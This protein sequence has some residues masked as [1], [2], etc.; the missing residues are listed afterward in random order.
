MAACSARLPTAID[1]VNTRARRRSVAVDGIV[2]LNKPAGMTA[3]AALGRVKRLLR[4]NK[5]GHTGTLDPA[6]TGML[7]LCFGEATKVAAFLLNADKTYRVAARLGEATDTGDAD[8]EIVAQK[9]VPPLSAR[10]WR[11]LLQEFLGTGEQIPPMYSALKRDGERL[12]ELARRGELVDRS[13]RRIDISEIALTEARG[14]RLVFR[15][16]CSKGTYVRTLVEDLAARAGTVAHTR[17]LHRESIA[18]FESASM[19][20]LA[21]VARRI[22]EDRL[23]GLLQAPDVALAHF[24][25]V[26][27]GAEQAAGFCQ[28][29]AVKVAGAR[30]A[31]DGLLRVYGPD[32]RFFGLAAIDAGGCL[33]PKRVFRETAAAAPGP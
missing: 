15:V 29:R 4:A 16:R 31:G 17:R 11:E 6:A 10:E 13:P 30:I 33:A 22:G 14:R 26:S 32:G 19:L 28:G 2:V 23:G 12:Y 24:A 8:G 18:G 21:A 3:N 1:A 25:A 9:P 5:A 20:S 27:I 7:P